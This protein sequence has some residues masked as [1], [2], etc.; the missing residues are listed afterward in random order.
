MHIVD[1]LKRLK[2][3]SPQ[4]MLELYPPFFF[5]GVKVTG[6]SQDSRK[7][8][9]KLPLR[10]YGRNQ[11]GTMFGGF[12]CAVSDPLA[13]L[14]CARH[15]PGHEVWTKSNFVEFLRPARSDLHIDVEITEADLTRIRAELEAKGKSAPV[16]ESYFRDA[17]GRE[18]ALVR[19]TVSIRKR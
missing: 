4:R 7:L 18:I 14:V 15:F 12:M 1:A 3:L 10:W 8:S 19:N 11:Y 17:K 13:A 9:V 2:F 16:F 6:V 5:M